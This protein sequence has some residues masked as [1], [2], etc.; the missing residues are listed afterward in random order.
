MKRLIT[1]IAAAALLGCQ[2]AAESEVPASDA[3]A[4]P[5]SGDTLASILDGMPDEAKARYQYRHPQETLEFFGIE[6]GM[7][8]VEGLPGGGATGP[9]SFSL[10]GL[11]ASHCDQNNDERVGQRVDDQPDPGAG[12]AKGEPVFHEGHSEDFA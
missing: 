12:E 7:T 9:G 10:L 4:T 3:A 6:P 8:V 1:L 5:A 2:P 11:V